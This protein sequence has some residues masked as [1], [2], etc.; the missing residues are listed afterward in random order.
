MGWTP[1]LNGVYQSIPTW[2][3]GQVSVATDW[4]NYVAGNMNFL[5]SPPMFRVYRSASYTAISAN[6]VPWDTVLFDTAGGYSTQNFKYTVMYAGL[7][8]CGM[9]VNQVGVSDSGYLNIWMYRTGTDFCYQYGTGFGNAGNAGFLIQGSTVC[10]VGD[11]LYG[12]FNASASL[13]E[14][15]GP[16]Q[17]FMYGVKISN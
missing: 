15:T 4:N 3:V 1:T 12:A 5:A 2:V 14:T 8:L 13:A 6:P 11:T 16:T 10:A 17:N 7:Y 9:G